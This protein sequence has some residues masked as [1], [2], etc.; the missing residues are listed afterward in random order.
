MSKD[1]SGRW[2]RWA[3]SPELP[4]AELQ[5][6]RGS[7]LGPCLAQAFSKGVPLWW[8]PLQCQRECPRPC[9]LGNSR[10]HSPLLPLFSILNSHT[11]RLPFLK[12]CNQNSALLHVSLQMGFLELN[13][14]TL[15]CLSVPAFIPRTQNT[16]QS[17]T[18]KTPDATSGPKTETFPS[19]SLSLRYVSAR[20]W[21][22]GSI[23]AV[24]VST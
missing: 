19:Q 1:G 3:E 13:S 15:S 17:K 2:G 12:V 18:S 6:H 20:P 14:F 8:S 5:A 24:F 7:C 11:H 16:Y 9:H 22:G 21:C 23:L 10:P 4:V